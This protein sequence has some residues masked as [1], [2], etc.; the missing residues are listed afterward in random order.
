MKLKDNLQIKY[1]TG[2][3]RV[4][5]EDYDKIGLAISL[6]DEI[7]ASRKTKKTWKFSDLSFDDKIL[8]KVIKD[9]I[10]YKDMLISDSV[11]EQNED[12][13]KICEN[14]IKKIYE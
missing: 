1:L 3:Y 9:N 5:V 11:I 8:S 13:Y 14:F 10:E 6:V 2:A 12:T 7:M 4:L